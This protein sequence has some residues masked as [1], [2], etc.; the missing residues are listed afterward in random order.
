MDKVAVKGF[1]R[2][3]KSK[4]KISIVVRFVIYRY[5]RSR[6]NWGL[7]FAKHYVTFLEET[8]SKIVSDNGKLVKV[9]RLFR[10]SES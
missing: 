8:G 3:M 7:A 9:E 2:F 1:C 10:R 4:L 6:K 5:R